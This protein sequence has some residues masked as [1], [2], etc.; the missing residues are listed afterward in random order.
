MDYEALGKIVGGG[1][2]GFGKG[3]MDPGMRRAYEGGRSGFSDL[4]ENQRNAGF[5]YDKSD[6]SDYVFESGRRAKELAKRRRLGVGGVPPQGGGV[7]R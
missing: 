6:T 1:L 7:I 2:G 4:M 3:L 5:V